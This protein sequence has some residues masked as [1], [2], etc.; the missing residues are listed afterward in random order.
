[1][2]MAILLESRVQ[3]PLILLEPVVKGKSRSGGHD[4]AANGSRE[5]NERG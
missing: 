4:E 2:V 5:E 1:M 3:P